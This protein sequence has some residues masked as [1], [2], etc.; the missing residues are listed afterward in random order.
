MRK[1]GKIYTVLLT[2]LLA[3]LIL[4]STCKPAQAYIEQ[5]TWLPGYVY[6]GYDNYYDYYY[7]IIAYMNGTTAHIRMPVRNDWYSPYM[8]V[9]AVSIVFGW[10]K[11]ITKDY[12]KPNQVR[13]NYSDVKYFELSF[14]ADVKDF[15]NDMAHTYII[16]VK[17]EWEFGTGTWTRYWN[18]YSPYYKFVVFLQNQKD[19]KDLSMKY[20]AYSSNYPPYSFNTIKGRLLATQAGVEASQAQTLVGI[21]NFTA[22]KTH[23]QTA[24][25]LYDDAFAVE[26][27]K[28]VAMEDAALNATITGADAA[29]KEADAAMLEAQ[30]LMNQ[31]YGYILLGLGFVLV[32]VGAILYGAKKPKTA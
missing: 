19:V 14:L 21:G 31:A 4:V 6:K 22:A 11:N 26:E 25:D 3:T 5:W 20:S 27:D 16:Y 10:G 30:A 15:P 1:T 32:G 9:T 12:S 28:G 17:Y 2:A 23:Y 8:N 7:P 13:I 29:V 24:V 18:D